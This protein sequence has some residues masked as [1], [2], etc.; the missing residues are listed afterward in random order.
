MMHGRSLI[1]IIGFMG[2]GKS[3]AGKK[4]AASL[5]WRFID[6][7]RE[8]EESTGTS[9]SRIFATSGEEKFR[10]LEAEA[11]DRLKNSTR[12]IISTGGGTPCHGNNMDVMT[13]TGIVVY[14]RMTPEQLALRLLVST[15]ERPLL[16]DITDEKLPGFIAAKLADREKWYNKAQIVVEGMNL[17][18]NNLQAVI[19]MESG[20]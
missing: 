15:G 5:G 9:I 1:Y 10:I 12:T 7:D 14:I 6:L 4:L 16:K 19:K 13:A 18:I 17:D 20:I 11:L 8:I 3:T 2:S